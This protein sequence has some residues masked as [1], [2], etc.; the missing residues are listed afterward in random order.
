MVNDD[1]TPIGTDSETFTI[2]V[3]DV[4]Q[5][6]TLAAIGPQ[7][8]CGGITAHLRREMASDPDGDAVTPGRVRPAH[9]RDLH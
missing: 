2:T 9:D 1:G 6:P 8:G 7:M 5:P 3:G 4:N